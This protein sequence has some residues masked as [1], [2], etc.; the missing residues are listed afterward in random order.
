MEFPCTYCHRAA[1]TKDHI[2]PKCLFPK[3]RPGSLIT[4]PSCFACNS[5]FSKDDEHLRDVLSFREELSDNPFVEKQIESIF[6]GFDRSQSQ[7]YL[8]YL[9]SRMGEEAVRTTSGIYL[10]LKATF[11][12][13]LTRIERVLRRITKGLYRH[14]FRNKLMEG[15]EAHVYTLEYFL[16]LEPEHDRIFR[17]IFQNNLANEEWF[18]VVPNGFEYKQKA[19][20]NPATTVW[21]FR[22]YSKYYGFAITLKEEDQ[23]TQ[24]KSKPIT[25]RRYIM[26]E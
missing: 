23:G 26:M 2:P 12:V 7:G 18:V 6:R 13:D 11:N 1:N 5:S 22:F 3:P 21:M 10:G 15:C 24:E 19:L 25:Y 17:S 16:S 14:C 4:V 20:Q 8:N 9:H